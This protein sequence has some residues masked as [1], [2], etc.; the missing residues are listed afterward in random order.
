MKNYL[1]TLCRLFYLISVLFL[2]L[3]ILLILSINI[4][5]AQEG[6]STLEQETADSETEAQQVMEIEKKKEQAQAW[7]PAPPPPDDFD[8]I[9]LTS[10]EW[11][12]GEFKGLYEKELEFDSDELDL[13][14]LDWEDVKQVRGHQVFSVRF[15]GPIT[16]IGVIQV[17]DDKVYVATDA[18]RQEFDRNQL[19][20]I[21]PG[22]PR[23][24]NYWSAKISIGLNL[25]EGNT[26]QVQYNSK[27]NVMRRT[28]AT[29]LML[30]YLG[31]FT[32]TDDVETVQNQR[33]NGNFDIMMTRRYYIRAIFAEYYRDPFQNIKGRGTVGAGIGYHIIDTSRTN[34]DVTAGPA[35]QY[36][37][38]VSVEAGED[39]SVSTPVFAAGTDFD[40]ELTNK[41]DFI[42]HYSFNVVDEESGQ[43]THH[44]ITSL[45]TEI[46]DILD[47]DISF[48]W[49]RTEK[50]TPRADGTVP[51]K[52]DYQL[53][54]WVGVDF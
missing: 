34:W 16:V 28:S 18:G 31:N 23:E 39:S 27:W 47:F 13:L 9:Q 3:C 2:P 5:H 42:I 10:G 11:L 6:D 40:I 20:A 7:L 33:V 50:P 21:A 37:E 43:Y 38:F 35:Y 54:F 1:P 25:S 26:D 29:R 22:E 32:T 45:E 19:I 48:V 15:E 17:T 4:T 49:D 36:T 12:K 46:T 44:A 51:E 52:D 14:K 41:I 53:I 8:W 24:I 30:D